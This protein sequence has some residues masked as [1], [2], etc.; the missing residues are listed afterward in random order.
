MAQSSTIIRSSRLSR[1]SSLAWLPSA[2]AMVSSRNSSHEQH[3]L[4]LGGRGRPL[5]LL[6]VDVL[7]IAPA[8]E[9]NVEP[10][11]LIERGPVAVVDGEHV[12]EHAH[13]FVEVLDH[14][15]VEL[16][17]SIEERLLLAGPF[18]DL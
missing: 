3:L 18:H 14:L 9:T 8:P 7:E 15:F 2:R 13:R 10:L 5:R 17:R 16:R 4:L 1:S 6:G 11:Q 12:L